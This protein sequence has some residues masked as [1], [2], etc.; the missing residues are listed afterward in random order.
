MKIPVI[1]TV[2]CYNYYPVRLT[3]ITI[4]R[5]TTIDFEIIQKDALPFKTQGDHIAIGLETGYRPLVLKGVNLGSSPP[6]Y[7]RRMLH[8]Q[9]VREVSIPQ[10]SSPK[11][12]ISGIGPGVG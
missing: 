4:S 5:D 3:D 1:T 6:G 2:S 11:G 7:I 10:V 9:A 8:R 12:E